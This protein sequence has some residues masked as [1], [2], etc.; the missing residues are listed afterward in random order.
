M[1]SMLFFLCVSIL[2]F[3][4]VFGQE[5]GRFHLTPPALPKITPAKFEGEMKDVTLPAATSKIAVGG[6]GRYLVCHLPS[7]RHLV[8]VDVCEARAIK[9]LPLSSDEI[10]FSASADKLLVLY[11]DQRV[12]RRYSLPQLELELTRPVPADGKLTQVCIGGASNGPVLMPGLAPV[13]FLDLK[14][15]GPARILGANQRYGMA[16]FQICWASMDGTLFTGC[17]SG[18]SPTGMSAMVLRGTTYRNLYEHDSNGSLLPNS[19]GT[20]IH[21]ARG[22]FSEQLV[23]IGE[24]PP[25]NTIPSVNGNFYLTPDK[26]GSATIHYGDDI[27]PLFRLPKLFSKED[28]TYAFARPTNKPKPF[29][30]PNANVLIFP[31]VDASKLRFFRLDIKQALDESGIDYLFV[32]ST[33][34]AEAQRGKQYHYQA[35]VQSKRG[36]LKFSIESGPDGMMVSPEGRVSWLVPNDMP[37]SQ[38][39]VILSVH[40]SLGQEVF[41][42]FD[43]SL[44]GTSAPG[45]A[46]V[47]K[48]AVPETAPKTASNQSDLNAETASSENGTAAPGDIRPAQLGREAKVTKLPS[49]V[50]SIRAAAGGKYLLLHLA[51]LRQ[52]AVFDVQQVKVVKYIPLSSDD[53][54]IAA[55]GEDMVLL[56]RSKQIAMSYDLSNFERR[57]TASVPVVGDIVGIE[58]GSNSSGP[59]FLMQSDNRQIAVSALNPKNFQVLDLGLSEF[60]PRSGKTMQVSA[61]ASVVMFGGVLGKRGPAGGKYSFGNSSRSV[62]GA[63]SATG[64]VV[65]SQGR[66]YDANLQQIGKQALTGQ[67][68]PSVQPGYFLVSNEGSVKLHLESEFSPLGILNYVK[69]QKRDARRTYTGQPTQLQRLW[70]IPDANHLIVIPEDSNR[71]ESYE[72]DVL[73]VLDESGVDYL[74]VK[75]SALPGVQLGKDYKT[76]IPIQSK[77]GGVKCTLQSGP[78]GLQ[79]S[80]SGLIT[81]RVPKDYSEAAPKLIVEIADASNRTILHTQTLQV[82]EALVV[83]KAKA[84]AA[85]LAAKK[86]REEMEAQ[87]RARRVQMLAQQL[88]QKGQR[89]LDAVNAV[90]ATS[91]KQKRDRGESVQVRTWTDQD[92]NQLEAVLVNQFAGIANLKSAEGAT[93][94]APISRLVNE[95]QEFLR[96][97]SRKAIEKRQN[98]YSSTDKLD[99]VASQLSRMLRNSGSPKKSRLSWRV[100]MLPLIGGVELYGL[101]DHESSWDSEHNKKLIPLIPEL[102]RASNTAAESGKT[103]FLAFAGPDAAYSQ[104]GFV[105]RR[106]FADGIEFSAVAAE[107]PAELADVWTKPDEWDSER[108]IE[109]LFGERSEILVA[110]GHGKVLAIARGLAPVL[111]DAIKISDGKRF[112]SDLMQSSNLPR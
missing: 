109:Q 81:W 36:G 66:F 80:E 91:I 90:T 62:V 42:V 11:R 86:A 96:A 26:E 37:D 44:S 71:L 84:E 87:L 28:F 8:L 111:L 92:G 68:I 63:I 19:S 65:F 47:A 39:K 53:V 77:R 3:Q 112:P 64:N 52:I 9:Y 23:R 13:P 75:P 107:V 76:Q 74:F 94:M 85:A 34:L 93:F 2:A 12:L 57:M 38:V 99:L 49:A 100:Q 4:P 88:E 7:L 60:A 6:G 55:S 110:F 14:S 17:R 104:G 106:R 1:L 18:G 43:L 67:V 51:A 32:D 108:P 56:D 103:R 95:D 10:D 33:P 97:L 89:A 102:F 105:D 20:R 72:L 78:S 24:R 50:S 83:A 98:G 69:V 46:G 30:I 58:M 21:T 16:D 45:L 61:D 29:L 54:L 22:I 101:F 59:L 27:R 41:Q 40:D 25:N 70:Y 82:P 48:N 35:N 73:K 79:V 15:L 31:L 5:E